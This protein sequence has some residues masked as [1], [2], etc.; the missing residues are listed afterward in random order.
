MT[1]S[2]LI[3]SG[4]ILVAGFLL[5]I[6]PAIVFGFLQRNIENSATH[7]IAVVV[8]LVIGML[9]IVQSGTS[10]FPSIIEALGW[11]FVVAAFSL[12]VIG[13]VKF[14]RMMSWV[15][16]NLKSFGRVAGIISIGFGGYLLFAFL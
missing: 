8:R 9:L 10:R 6:N 15:L 14:R 5:L 16:I 3:F 13:K 1:I 12:A 11:V 4:M 2:I 7:L